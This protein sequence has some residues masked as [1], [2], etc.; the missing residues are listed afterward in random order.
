MY[1]L[2]F[3]FRD[4]IIKVSISFEVQLRKIIR[5]ITSDILIILEII[6]YIFRNI[7][8]LKIFWLI[9]ILTN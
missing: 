6:E 1:F 2:V 7:N 5:N 8:Y 3:L 9:I 4:V